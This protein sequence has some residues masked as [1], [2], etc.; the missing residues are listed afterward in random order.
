MDCTHTGGRPA[1]VRQAIAAGKHIHIEKP[2]AM[3]VAECETLLGAAEKAG[4]KPSDVIIVGAGTTAKTGTRARN[5]P[6]SPHSSPAMITA[7]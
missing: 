1:R 4:V 6:A 3:S 7:R 5:E 2:F